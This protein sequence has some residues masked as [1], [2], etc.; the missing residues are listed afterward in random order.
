MER[1]K[2]EMQVLAAP[3]QFFGSNSLTLRH[4]A[5]DT[6]LTFNALDALRGE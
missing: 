3:E 5:S 4:E 6:V 2:D 1:L